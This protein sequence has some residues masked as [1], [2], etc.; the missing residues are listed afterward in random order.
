[1]SKLL[2]KVVAKRLQHNIVAHKLIPTT[3]F[4][5]CAHSSCLDAGLTLM[6][7]IQAAHRVGL[8]CGILLFNIQ[9]FFNHV[10]HDCMVAI[11]SNMGFPVA[12]VR[13]MAGFL[14][15]RKVCL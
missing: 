7:D 12:L 5:G 13:W 3:Q 4:G 6:H 2:E 15:D 14:R 9:G 1:M 11:L 8:K 10:N